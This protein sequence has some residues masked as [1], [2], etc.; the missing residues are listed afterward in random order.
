MRVVFENAFLW[1]LGIWQCY[2]RAV[3]R[4]VKLCLLIPVTVMAKM[5]ILTW[6]S[7]GVITIVVQMSRW[8]VHN[9]NKAKGAT[10]KPGTQRQAV[11]IICPGSALES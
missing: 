9:V 7:D 4:L 1:M 11:D 6:I 2:L 3:T 5:T 8:S 10:T